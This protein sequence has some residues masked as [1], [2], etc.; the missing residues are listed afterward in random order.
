MDNYRKITRNLNVHII[1]E[2]NCVQLIPNSDWSKLDFLL[3]DLPNIEKL[4]LDIWTAVNQKRGKN[5]LYT[6]RSSYILHDKMKFLMRV[7]IHLL[8]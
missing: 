3:T 4:A 5:S 2:T 1:N 7:K 8:V 6:I